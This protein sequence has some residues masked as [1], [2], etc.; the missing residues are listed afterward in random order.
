MRN[1]LVVLSEGLCLQKIQEMLARDLDAEYLNGCRL[2]NKDGVELHNED[3]PYL[4]ENSD[5]FASKG[6]SFLYLLILRRGF[7]R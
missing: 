1:I 2:F 3:I 5:L 6:T 7:R 4:K